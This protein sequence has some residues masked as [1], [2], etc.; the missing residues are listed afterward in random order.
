MFIKIISLFIRAYQIC[1]SPIL[2]PCCR[3]TPTCSEYSIEAL[4]SHGII[5]GS[6]ISIKRILRC[7][8]LGKS[9]FDPV[10]NTNSEEKCK[11]LK[12]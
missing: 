2:P 12:T 9:G 11:T 1:I 7:N 6:Y 10:P 4:K 5:K 8:P 3:Y